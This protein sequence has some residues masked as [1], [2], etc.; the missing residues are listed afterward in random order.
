MRVKFI[1]VLILCFLVAACSRV[2]EQQQ[3]QIM[4]I[5]Q[6]A[7]INADQ[8]DDVWRQSLI[9]ALESQRPGS[10]TCTTK[11][12]IPRRVAQDLGLWVVQKSMASGLAATPGTFSSQQITIF[13][14]SKKIASMP[15]PHHSVMSVTL[16]SIIEHKGKY[17]DMSGTEL[18]EQ[19]TQQ[20]DLAN[21]SWDLAILV[22]G[23]IS[24]K[25][26]DEET[27]IGGGIVGAAYLY[28]HQKQAVVCMGYL[29]AQSSESVTIWKFGDQQTDT[30]AHLD[31]DLTIKAIEAAMASLRQVRTQ[32]QNR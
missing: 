19:A 9:Q 12:H 26:V 30:N 6:A 3:L 20:A 32:A 4:E 23:E 8:I 13:Y 18:I 31:A 7:E 14:D 22:G 29:D 28:D 15:S 17:Q 2:S 24:A 16:S 1:Q 25:A 27:F 10:E 5:A 21:W 11:T